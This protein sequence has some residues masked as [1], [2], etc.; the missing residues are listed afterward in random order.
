MVRPASCF[1]QELTNSPLYVKCHSLTSVTMRPSENAI[2][3]CSWDAN[4]SACRELGGPHWL[5]KLL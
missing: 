5:P 3:F 2:C 1:A 4:D